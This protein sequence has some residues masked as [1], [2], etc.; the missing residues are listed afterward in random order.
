MFGGSFGGAGGGSEL[1]EQKEALEAE[2]E[3]LKAQIKKLQA[4]LAEKN[5]KLSFLENKVADAEHETLMRIKQAEKK[6]Q[7]ETMKGFEEQN[8]KFQEVRI[9]VRGAKRRF[10]PHNIS[11]DANPSSFSCPLLLSSLS[12]MSQ[13][14]DLLQ[15]ERGQE[16]AEH[17]KELDELSA[18]LKKE[19]DDLKLAGKQSIDH[20]KE[21]LTA[22]QIE[23]D[24]MQEE[25][26]SC[27]ERR[28]RNSLRT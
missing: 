10:F 11:T 22:K 23:L 14:L 12:Q 19:M 20:Y 1:Q 28:V 17:K 25:V 16:E 6:M 13:M 27:E 15:S 7:K 21:E 24:D 8:R 26:R 18:N 4:E 9:N 2:V 5:D 3:D